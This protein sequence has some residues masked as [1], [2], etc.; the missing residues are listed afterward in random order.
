MERLKILGGWLI[1]SVIAGALLGWIFNFN[2]IHSII[3][4][5]GAMVVNFLCSYSILL[6]SLLVKRYVDRIEKI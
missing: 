4:A 3:V 2:I 6:F 1:V 5:F